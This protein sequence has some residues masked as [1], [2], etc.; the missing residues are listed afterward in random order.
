MASVQIN[1]SFANG[2]TLQQFGKIISERMKWMHETARD[3][4]AACAIN[5][6]K[7]IRTVTKV[8][9]LSSIKVDVKVDAALYPS[10]TTL[11]SKKQPCVRFKGS[12]KR[13]LGNERLVF[14]DK[15]AEIQ[16]W[17]V[18]RFTDNLSPKLTSY[19]IVAPS[20]GAA[21][22]KAKSIVRSRQIRYAGLAKRAL[23]VL[24][25]KINT[26]KVADAVPMHVTSKAKQL[27]QTKE[28]VAKSADNS[29]GKYA[30]VMLD[31]LKYALDA[32]KGG[33][34]TVDTQLKKAMNKVVSIINKKIPDSDA[35]FGHRKLET[36]FP[37]LVGKRKK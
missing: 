30:L 3:S 17:F 8:A 5:M 26:K 25:M 16:T 4:I 10:Y 12:K 37:E 21:K 13:Y 7:S 6:L 31:E 36:P 27:T 1:A 33:R 14:A 29:G 19:L 18:Y 15:P 23:G 35:F 34:A 28:I 24:M 2:A 20:L 9:K 11:S 22:A 32:I